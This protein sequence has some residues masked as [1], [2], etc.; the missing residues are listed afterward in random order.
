TLRLD[1][2]QIG[3]GIADMGKG[4]GDD[5]AGI[6]RTGEDFLVARHRGVETDLADRCPFGPQTMTPEHR[7]IRQHHDARIAR[8]RGCWIFRCLGHDRLSK[9]AAARPL[10]AASGRKKPPEGDGKPRLR[11]YGTDYNDGAAASAHRVNRGR[12]LSK[13]HRA[14]SPL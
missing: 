11:R 5:L 2:F 14:S 6:G 8:A 9:L 12:T 3:A 13:C 4:E 1:I 7:T 10:R